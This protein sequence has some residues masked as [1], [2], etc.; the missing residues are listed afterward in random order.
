MEHFRQCERLFNVRDVPHTFWV[1]LTYNYIN[2]YGFQR[3]L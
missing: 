1:R 2:C 3:L